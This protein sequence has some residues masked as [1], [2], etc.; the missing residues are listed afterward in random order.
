VQREIGIEV[1]G[2]VF[3]PECDGRGDEAAAV[4]AV[5]GVLEDA[6]L[7]LLLGVCI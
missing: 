2:Q 4:G 3:N 5:D 7:L 6:V 1:Q